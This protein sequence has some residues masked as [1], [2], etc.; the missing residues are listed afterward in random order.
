[1]GYRKKGIGAWIMNLR[2]DAGGLAIIGAIVIIIIVA[3]YYQWQNSTKIDETKAFLKSNGFKC[4][5]NPDTRFF[6]C[7]NNDIKI[8]NKS[9]IFFKEYL[10][11]CNENRC[12]LLNSKNEELF[13]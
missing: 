4:D 8:V 11:F 13:R 6:I 9:V 1:M 2:E 7:Q 10:F 3:G 5:Y 12:W